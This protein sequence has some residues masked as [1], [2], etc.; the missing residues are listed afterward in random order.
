MADVAAAEAA[1]QANIGDPLGISVVD[2]WAIHETVNESPG[3]GV[4]ALEKAKNIADYAM[5]PIGGAGP[6]HACNIALKQRARVI[7]P[8]CR[9]G[10]RARVPGVA[11]RFHLRP[12]WR[13]AAGRSQFDHAR[14]T[15]QMEQEVKP[16]R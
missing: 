10:V 16:C 12:W 6:V 3:I 1:L 5:V 14:N 9:C 2:A 8:Q 4:H 13:H 7:C 11:N 15:D